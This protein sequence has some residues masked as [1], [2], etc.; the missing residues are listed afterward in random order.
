MKNLWVDL[1]INPASK[2]III[3]S[4]IFFILFLF[5]LVTLTILVLLNFQLLEIAYFGSNDLETRTIPR[6][7]KPK[8]KK[9]GKLCLYF[10]GRL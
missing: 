8:N 1:I 6:N 2:I 5:S 4:Y 9:E 10:S 3:K 7:L